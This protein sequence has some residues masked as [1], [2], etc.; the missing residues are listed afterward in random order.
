MFFLRVAFADEMMPQ[1][2]LHD[3]LVGFFAS[4]LLRCSYVVRPP[5]FLLAACSVKNGFLFIYT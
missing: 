2:C 4:Y 3:W 1:Q 5:M